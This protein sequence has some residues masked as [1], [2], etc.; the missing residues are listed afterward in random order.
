VSH[1]T[2]SLEVTRQQIDSAIKT[3]LGL[4]RTP[5]YMSPRAAGVV[6]LAGLV[7]ATLA[8]RSIAQIP[9]P[10]PPTQQPP[11]FRSGVE[12]VPL[13]VVVTDEHNQPLV[14]LTKDDFAVTE[15]GRSQRIATFAFVSVPPNHRL[16]DLHATQPPPPDVAVNSLAPNSRALVYVID[17]TFVR[18]ADI[19]PLKQVMTDLLR[20]LSPTDTAAVLYIKRSDLGQDFTNDI[21]RLIQAVNHINAAIG[22]RPDPGA[23]EATERVI[24]NV[25]ATLTG[26]PQTRRAIVYVSSGIP[27]NPRSREWPTWLDIWSR[28]RRADVPIYTVDPHGLLSPELLKNQRPAGQASEREGFFIPGTIDIDWAAQFLESMAET[29]GGLAFVHQINGAQAATELMTDNGSYYLL[30]YYPDPLVRDGK[31]HA[32]KVTVNRPGARV[33]AREGY[34]APGANPVRPDTRQ[35]LDAAMG[36]GLDTAALSLRTFAAPVVAS[37]KGMTTIV[38]VEVSY[39][40]TSDGPLTVQDNLQ[41]SVLALDPD[42]RVKAQVH[43]PLRFSARTASGHTPPFLIDAAID[44]PSQALTIRVGVTSASLARTGTTH[45]PL[46]VPNPRD[47]TLQFGGL[48]LG[49]VG[50]SEPV[51]GAD[52]ISGLVPFQPTTSRTFAPG[53]TLQ[54]WAPVFWGS[55]DRSVEVSLTILHDASTVEA[56]H[57]AATASGIGDNRHQATVTTSVPLAGLAPGSYDL[58]LG[59]RLPNGQVATRAVPFDVR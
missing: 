41:M 35:L 57:V 49:L 24:E 42:G 16:V 56:R 18:A 30:G 25:T 27:I 21:G 43:L 3:G 28:A 37:R 19:V 45:V 47:D 5:R 29:T 36:A 33:R 48:V 6:A 2:P 20:A 31:F 51:L 50:A 7:V 55:K 40:S 12:Y 39:P 59:A 58:E 8:V 54:V 14:N 32:V 46:T 4:D 26:A 44:L 11:V 13:D 22:W 10:P 1:G 17:D 38:T 34:I 53:N 23:P 9:Q 15:N 52:A